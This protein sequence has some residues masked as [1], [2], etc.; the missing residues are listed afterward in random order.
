MYYR[1]FWGAHY[2]RSLT[3]KNKTITII[4][5]HVEFY[6]ILP[7]HFHSI[8]RS[9]HSIL[10]ALPQIIQC[11]S[12]PLS[13][14]VLSHSIYPRLKISL[15]LSIP[16]PLL[17]FSILISIFCGFFSSHFPYHF[18]SIFSPFPKTD[19]KFLLTTFLAFPIDSILLTPIFHII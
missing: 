2:F 16:I 5:S 9:F 13:V 17:Y 11:Q 10:H 7:L 8:P 1:Y 12:I 15:P 4:F 18:H 19:I 14:P 6:I 3:G